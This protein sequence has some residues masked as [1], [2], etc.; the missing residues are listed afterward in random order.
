MKR[1]VLL[2]L[3]ILTAP[4]SAMYRPYNDSFNYVRVGGFT[5]LHMPLGAEVALGHR[6]KIGQWGIGPLVNLSISPVACPAFSLKFESLW[7][8]SSWHGSCYFGLM[9]GVGVAYLEDLFY[10]NSGSWVFLPTL[11]FLVGREF[12]SCSGQKH[13]YYFSLSPYYSISFN[14]GWGF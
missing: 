3:I 13:F 6:H 11:E 4:L 2:F 14:Y 10:N 8:P 5:F 1:I 9:P 12:V 7:Y